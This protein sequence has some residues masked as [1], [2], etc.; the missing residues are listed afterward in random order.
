MYE[1]VT[2]P[3][4]PSMWYLESGK[5]FHQFAWIG[6]TKVSAANQS[7]D[8]VLVC[9]LHGIALFALH[10]EALRCGDKAAPHCETGCRSQEDPG[11]FSSIGP[12]L[13]TQRRRM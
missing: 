6:P 2:P 8:G 13:L 5:G 12:A 11:E 3:S 10:G 7:P 1:L 9:S 4:P